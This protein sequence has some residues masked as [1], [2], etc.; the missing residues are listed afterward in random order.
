MYVFKAVKKGTL[1]CV[2]FLKPLSSPIRVKAHTL[3]D[4]LSELMVDAS[5]GTIQCLEEIVGDPFH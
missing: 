5:L 1:Q 4:S 2:L 3:V